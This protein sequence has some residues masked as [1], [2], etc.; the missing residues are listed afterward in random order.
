MDPYTPKQES[1][2]P[3]I[4]LV[5][6]DSKYG[7]LYKVVPLAGGKEEHVFMSNPSDHSLV[8]EAKGDNHLASAFFANGGTLNGMDVSTLT[9]TPTTVN[10]QPQTSNIGGQSQQNTGG[11]FA[12]APSTNVN[13]VNAYQ[14]MPNSGSSNELPNTP[15]STV[16]SQSPEIVEKPIP[17]ILSTHSPNNSSVLTDEKSSPI[18]PNI[19]NSDNNSA[20]TNETGVPYHTVVHGDTMTNIAQANNMTQQHLESHNPQ[21]NDPNKI[22]P[23]EKVYL[24]TPVGVGIPPPTSKFSIGENS[25]VTSPSTPDSVKSANLIGDN[26]SPIKNFETDGKTD[27]WH[28][29]STN[30]HSV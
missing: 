24:N 14:A 20:T 2:Y 3:Y 6:G 12:P 8:L 13:N 10:T 28:P 30:P 4:N 9:P 21:I 15:V 19:N 26:D 29:G 16:S 22:Y 27:L 5:K 17:T 25:K 1:E 23:G 18:N 11:T 7:Q